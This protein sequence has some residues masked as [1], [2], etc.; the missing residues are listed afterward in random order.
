ML[1]RLTGLLLGLAL[2]ITPAFAGGDCKDGQKCEQG[3]T[4]DQSGKNGGDCC[5]KG[6]KSGGDC[7]D[8]GGKDGGD[9]CDKGGKSGGDCCDQAKDGK[10][11]CADCKDG[12]QGA[13]NQVCAE[14]SYA[15]ASQYTRCDQHTCPNDLA[16]Q[17]GKQPKRWAAGNPN[18]GLTVRNDCCWPDR[19]ENVRNACR[20]NF[21][22]GMPVWPW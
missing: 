2:L 19:V 21:N 14:W 20:N 7:C 4:C 1:T 6:G 5:D 13:C 9:C 17:E 10:D 3:Q 15:E 12:G 18:Y 8:Q 16:M 11:G 22:L